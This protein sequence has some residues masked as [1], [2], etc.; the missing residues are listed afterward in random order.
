MN[1]DRTVYHEKIAG[2]KLTTTFKKLW[3]V[4]HLII[5]YKYTY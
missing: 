5:E 4:R 3:S 2:L 1:E